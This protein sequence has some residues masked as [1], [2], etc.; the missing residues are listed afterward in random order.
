MNEKIIFVNGANLKTLIT[1]ISL[2]WDSRHIPRISCNVID[3]LVF[4]AVMWA[5][6]SSD[7]GFFVTTDDYVNTVKVPAYTSDLS[8]VLSC[9]SVTFIRCHY[10]YLWSLDRVLE[11]M[12]SMFLSLNLTLVLYK[13]KWKL[14]DHLVVVLETAKSCGV[15]GDI[16]KT[17]HDTDEIFQVRQVTFVSLICSRPH[18]HLNYALRCT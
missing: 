2:Q 18:V 11:Q 12:A 10:C 4:D 9:R 17:D 15:Y 1:V 14:C 16:N 6:E 7:F 5:F 8:Q 3:Y 13:M